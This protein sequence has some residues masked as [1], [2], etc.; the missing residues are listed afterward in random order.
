MPQRKRVNLVKSV[1]FH[2]I[3]NFK[4][5]SVSLPLSLLSQI[6][7]K[8]EFKKSLLKT[9]DYLCQQGGFF[10][11]WFDFPSDDSLLIRHYSYM[12]AYVLRHIRFD[13]SE[14]RIHIFFT[15]FQNCLLAFTQI[16]IIWKRKDLKNLSN[17]IIE[18]S[19]PLSNGSGLVVIFET[20]LH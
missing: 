20:C 12:I 7:L 18:C 6:N 3:G 9:K 2:K 15:N 19:R 17:I 4:S 14:K 13:T 10:L 1:F 8:N 11:I 5:F 16:Q